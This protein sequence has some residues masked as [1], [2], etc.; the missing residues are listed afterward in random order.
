MIMVYLESFLPIVYYTFMCWKN[1]PKCCSMLVWI[2]DCWFSSIIYSQAIIPR[3]IV[4]SPAFLEHGSAEKIAVRAHYNLW[5]Q[6]VGGLDAFIPKTKNKKPI[7]V[8]VFLR[9]FQRFHS[10]A[11]PIWPDYTLIQCVELKFVFLY[12]RL[13]GVCLGWRW[14]GAGSCCRATGSWTAGTRRGS[15]RSSGSSAITPST[16]SPSSIHT[17]STSIRSLYSVKKVYRFSIPQPGCHWP[18]SPWPGKI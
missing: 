10:E 12:T 9:P 1:P 17:S 4:D 14:W 6:Q 7:A 3:T 16:T 8:D 5:S 18:N 2:A 15:W 13:V 11:D